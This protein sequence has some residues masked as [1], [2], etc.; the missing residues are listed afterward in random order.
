MT[1]PHRHVLE[2]Y[3]VGFE[4]T[5]NP[6]HLAVVKRPAVLSVL[7]RS[8]REGDALSVLGRIETGSAR[9][10]GPGEWLLVSEDASAS[11]IARELTAAGDDVLHFTDQSDGRVVLRL[12]GPSVRKIL[13][14]CLA[15]DVHPDEFVVG[16]STPTQCCHVV[17][18]LARTGENTF[19]L[20]LPRSFAG[21]VFEEIMEMGREYAMTAGFA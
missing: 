19:E 1:F 7:A 18:N 11:S 3:I 17:A 2:D 8:G 21:H 10:A 15:V 4:G 13:A 16:A 6:H 14:K 12:A 20:I 9:F 5:P